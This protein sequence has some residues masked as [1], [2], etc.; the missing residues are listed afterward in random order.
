[1]NKDKLINFSVIIPMY[2]AE[3][4]I[5]KALDSVRQQSCYNY[6]SEIIVINDGSLDLSLILVERYKTTYQELP[7]IIINKTNEGVSSARNIGMRIAQGEWIALLDADDQWVPDKIQKQVD[8]LQRNLDIDFLGGNINE[9]VLS[10]LGRKIKTLYKASIY[11]LCI[12]VF[13]QTSTAVFKRSIYE[14]IGGYDEKQKYGED[15]NY[16]MK[17]CESYNYY[18]LPVQLVCYGDDKRGFG[19]SGLSANLK[20]MHKGSVKNIKELKNKHIISRSFY[21][22]LRL[23]YSLK[24]MRRILITKFW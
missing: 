24:Y 11:D 3:N 14:T 2:N 7:L 19:M 21:W 22:F 16:F 9:K 4:T 6:I 17:I 5:I 15:V 12:K 20:E 13:P 10:I 18:H 8:V 1:M 23:F